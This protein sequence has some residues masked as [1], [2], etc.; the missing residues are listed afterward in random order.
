MAINTAIIVLGF[1]AP[2]IDEESAASRISLLEW[3][4]LELGRTGWIRFTIAAPAVIVTGAL[5]AGLGAALRV[6]G[7]AYLGPGVVQSGEMKAQGVMADGPYRHL[8]NPL[9]LGLWLMAA[10]MALVMP[11]TGALVAMAILT[12]YLLRLILVEEAFLGERMGEPYQ[13]Y[14]AA[15][16]RLLPRLR[17]SVASAHAR[18]F[19]V[20]AVAAELLPIGVF[21]TLAFFS[22]TYDNRL[23][24]RALLISFGVSLVARAFLPRA[25]SEPGVTSA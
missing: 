9:Y 7:T 17:T 16:P 12:I 1:W 21:V 5:V 3:I 6:W 24:G 13:A 20:R 19:W 8:R 22:W 2:W 4:A 11:A 18:P 23:M 25:T 14:L 10:A 15:V